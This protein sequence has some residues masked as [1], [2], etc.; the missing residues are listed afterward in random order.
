MKKECICKKNTEKTRKEKIEKA[1]NRSNINLFLS[2][3]AMQKSP[4]IKTKNALS[5][6]IRELT[7][8]KINNLAKE[9][10]AIT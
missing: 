7:R 3:R 2:T 1:M 10:A 9:L 4:K 6:I 8:L 5:L